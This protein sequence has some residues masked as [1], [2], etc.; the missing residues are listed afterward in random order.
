MN[1]GRRRI[2][3]RLPRSI[4]SVYDA[5]AMTLAIAIAPVLL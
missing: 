3:I 4:D 1:P 5:K 2:E